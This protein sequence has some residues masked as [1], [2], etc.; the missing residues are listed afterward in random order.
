MALLTY[1]YCVLYR[2]YY[3]TDCI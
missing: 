2:T 3:W 1:R